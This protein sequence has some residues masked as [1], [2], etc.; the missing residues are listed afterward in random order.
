MII[1]FNISKFTNFFI[2]ICRVRQLF[3]LFGQCSSFIMELVKRTFILV[4]TKKNL[5]LILNIVTLNK[6]STKLKFTRVNGLC[7][8]F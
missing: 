8:V 5:K 2:L 3:P 1:F 4:N 7:E 6:H